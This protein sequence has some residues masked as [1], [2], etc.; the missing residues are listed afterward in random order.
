MKEEQKSEGE[1]KNKGRKRREEKER[2]IKRDSIDPRG[3]GFS[4][5]EEDCLQI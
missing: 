1:E 3:R 2:K 5:F 4:H